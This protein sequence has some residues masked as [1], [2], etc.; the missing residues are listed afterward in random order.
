MKMLPPKVIKKLMEIG[1]KKGLSKKEVFKRL[2]Q[3]EKQEYISDISI[4]KPEEITGD[5]D[6]YFYKD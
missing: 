4:I 6:K 5:Y 3:I 1:Y 2:R